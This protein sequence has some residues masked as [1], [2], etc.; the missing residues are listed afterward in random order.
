MQCELVVERVR[1][2]VVE[3]SAGAE[4]LTYEKIALI[5]A[6]ACREEEKVPPPSP[7][8]ELLKSKELSYWSVEGRAELTSH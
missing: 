2:L 5:V 7:L 4:E 6:I 3:D 1:R 8:F